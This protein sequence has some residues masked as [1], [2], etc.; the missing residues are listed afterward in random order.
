MLELAGG[1][2][3]IGQQSSVT[4]HPNGFGMWIPSDGTW[5]YEG[6][7]KECQFHGKGRLI[8]E[9]KVYFEGEFYK[10]LMSGLGKVV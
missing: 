10:G 3:Y 5:L 4:G 8:Y 2:T 6:Y 1:H 9:S 7:F